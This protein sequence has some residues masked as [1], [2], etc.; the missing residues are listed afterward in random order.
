MAVGTLCGRAVILVLDTALFTERAPVFQYTETVST[1][2]IAAQKAQEGAPHLTCISAEYMSKGR[3]RRG[4]TW[5]TFRGCQLLLTF[6]IREGICPQLALAAS[7]GVNRALHNCTQ[8]PTTIK[9]PNDILLYNTKVA[10]IL[11]EM[12]NIGQ[13]QQCAL[14]GIGINVLNPKENVPDDFPGTFLEHHFNSADNHKLSREHVFNA[15]Y[16]ALEDVLS[17]IHN[18]GWQAIAANY[19]QQCVTVG[20]TI[21]W[22]TEASEI[23]G[24]ATGLAADGALLITDEYGK[25]H[26]VN[27]GDIMAHGVCH[28]AT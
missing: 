4:K 12:V 13:N 17:T 26:T 23:R 8:L 20:Q 25:Q 15:V 3:G 24:V 21:T 14:L 7:L 28:S 9:W 2:D 1:M 5:Q 10:G 18:K 19:A 22:L 6:I 16:E 27:A 11:V